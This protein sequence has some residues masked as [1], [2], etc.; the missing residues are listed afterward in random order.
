VPEV[1]AKNAESDFYFIDREDPD[2]I[3]AT[4]VEMIKTRI[5]S[6]FRIDP[7]LRPL[8]GLSLPG[9]FNDPLN[10]AALVDLTPLGGRREFLRDLGVD[11][12]SFSN[13]AS[14]HLPPALSQD[15]LPIEK[16]RQA[17]LLLAGRLGEILDDNATRRK[18]V[19]IP[20]V[21]CHD[22]IF[23]NPVGVYFQND[24]VKEVLGYG[25]P[26]ATVPKDHEAAVR[27]FYKW[28]GVTD[29][30]R[31]EDIVSRARH[32]VQQPP[33]TA[34]HLAVKKIFSHLGERMRQEVPKEAM[35][36]LQNLAWLPARGQQDNWYRPDSLYATFQDYLFESQASFLDIPR[37]VQ[38]AS[39][40]LLK[41]LGVNT[42]PTSALVVAHLLH[43]ASAGKAVNPEVYRFLN[44][45]ADDPAIRYL[46]DKPCLL[47]PDNTYVEPAV[48][49]WGEHPFGRFRK[50]LGLELRRFSELFA[51]LGIREMPDHTD[52]LKVLREISAAFGTANT[53]LD[54]EA[55]AVLL[56]CWRS[57]ELALEAGSLSAS[58]LLALKTVKCVPNPIRL[59]SP[60]EWMFFEDRAG[61]A[62]KFDGFLK[63]N[64]IP[65]PLGAWNAM[66][67]AGV[68]SLSSA[69]EV[70]LIECIHPVEDAEVSARVRERK[71]EL[72]RVLEAQAAHDQPAERLDQLLRIR[73]E[74]V[75]LL[76]IQYTLKAFGRVLESKPE[77]SPALFQREHELLTFIRQ[78]S[79][80]SWPSIARELALALFP[81]EEP[82]R[83][84]PGIKEVLAAGS[85]AEAKAVLDE[86]GFATLEAT[87][88]ATISEQHL[89][90]LGSPRWSSSR[91]PQSL[92]G[93][94]S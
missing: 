55:H 23:R 22:G 1:S 81:D 79:Q 26:F 6:K 39:T 59:L 43:N 27:G 24:I 35:L 41:F 14:N 15:I 63:A 37:D 74:S 77:S 86:L 87:R 53:I 84:A 70:H 66:T 46:K 25:I 56:H 73:F 10:L 45:H 38:I 48:V 19:Q 54:E 40:E 47:L 11:E 90:R 93:I 20:I 57:L 13:Y 85:E 12:L 91:K 65:R 18:L 82:G 60:P 4:L 69:V 72:G 17:V 78:G 62:V 42:S 3:A 36:P 67:A 33:N 61:I 94:Q 92:N 31:F 30:P 83:L 32:L 7:T 89:T 75:E 9:N 2:Q 16:R 50:R 71:N 52:A 58:Q 44:D 21:E 34:T 68:Q 49:F 64:V 5:P 29:S 51:K 76:K 80:P 28:L 88:P 8:V